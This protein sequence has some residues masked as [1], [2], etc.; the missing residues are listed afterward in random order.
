MDKG[1]RELTVKGKKEKNEFSSTDV[2]LHSTKERMIVTLC[3][4]ISGQI[5]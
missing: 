5:T 3:F 1:M 2:L 4:N